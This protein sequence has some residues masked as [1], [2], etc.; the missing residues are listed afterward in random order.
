MMTDKP[1]LLA[2]DGD[3]FDS[4]DELHRWIQERLNFPDYYGGNADALW[5]SLT[6]LLYSQQSVEVTWASFNSSRARFGQSAEVLRDTFIDAAK[7]FPTRA[8]V[9][10]SP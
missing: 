2:I 9:I 1:I 4:I 10:I 8:T 7:R 3:R 5:D 6:D